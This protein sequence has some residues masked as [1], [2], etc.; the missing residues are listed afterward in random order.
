MKT[1]P[2]C[3]RSH[4]AILTTVACL[5]TTLLLSPPH[6]ADASP[7]GLEPPYTFRVES[8]F[9]RGHREETLLVRVGRSSYRIPDEKVGYSNDAGERVYFN[10]EATPL[11]EHEPHLSPDGKWLLIVRK[12]G[13]SIQ[14]AYLYQLNGPQGARPIKPGGNRFDA[15]A[16]ASVAA[17]QSRKVPDIARGG[18]IYRFSQWTSDSQQLR[19]TLLFGPREKRTIVEAAYHIARNTFS[20]T[21]K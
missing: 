18:W 20:A 1:I 14:T 13:R 3:P 2:H 4:A 6:G 21:G 15:A 16:Y 9:V 10:D 11:Y 5:L 19:F 12:C 8:R 7:H 17:Q